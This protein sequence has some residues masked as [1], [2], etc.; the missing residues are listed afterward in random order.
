MAQNMITMIFFVSKEGF[1]L[2]R[3][4]EKSEDFDE[5]NMF[6]ELFSLIDNK[7]EI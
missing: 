1:W 2:S 4:N 3:N 6:F 5:E 7:N